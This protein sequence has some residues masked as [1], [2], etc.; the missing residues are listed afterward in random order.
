MAL[1][2]LSFSADIEFV[3]ARLRLWPKQFSH[4]HSN[5][6]T[7]ATMLAPLSVVMH[8]TFFSFNPHSLTA[9]WRDSAKLSAVWLSGVNAVYK[10]LLFGS[11]FLFTKCTVRHMT[12]KKSRS[13]SSVMIF[14]LVSLNSWGMTVFEKYFLL[15]SSYCLSNDSSI[16]RKAGFSTV[17]SVSATKNV[18]TFLV[19]VFHLS[20][21]LLYLAIFEKASVIPSLTSWALAFRRHD[22]RWLWRFEVIA[23]LTLIF[24]PQSIQ[25]ASSKLI[26]SPFSFGTNPKCSQI[27]DV[28]FGFPTRSMA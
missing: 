12:E 2:V 26:G 21:S 23:L 18:A 27:G 1:D 5:F 14:S 28:T 25:M 9:P 4:G 20:L 24:L 7:A 22:R 11:Q 15:R 13:C 16:S 17:R 19:N 10:H 6:L 8:A 3:T